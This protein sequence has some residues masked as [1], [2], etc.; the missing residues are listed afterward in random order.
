MG[1]MERTEIVEVEMPDGGVINAEVLV[2]DSITDIGAGSKLKLDEAKASIASFVRWAVGTVGLTAEDSTSAS[3]PDP[4]SP[5]G[6]IL[7]RVGLEFGLNLAVKS[8]TVTGVI[9][10]VGGEASAVVKLEWERPTAD[11]KE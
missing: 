8:G 5:P 4:V 7:S 1:I 3:T 9:V 11:G 2:S 6:M 10:S